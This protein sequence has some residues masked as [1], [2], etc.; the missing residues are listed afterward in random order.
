[1]IDPL[2][3]SALSV[4]TSFTRE[5]RRSRA[6]SALGGTLPESRALLDALYRPFNEDLT[7]LLEDTRFMWGKLDEG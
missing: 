7:E 5:N 2:N 1:M 4:I 3:Q 6:D